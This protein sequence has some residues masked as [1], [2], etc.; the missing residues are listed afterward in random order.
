MS[1]HHL[2]MIL[3]YYLDHMGLD[4]EDIMPPSNALAY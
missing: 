2:H 3:K 4:S 1:F